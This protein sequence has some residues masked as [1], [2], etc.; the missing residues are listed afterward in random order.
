MLGLP[1]NRRFLAACL[2][3]PTFRAGQALI[4][5]LAGEGDAI[6]E[7]LQKEELL[8]LIP[9]GLAALFSQENWQDGAAMALP[10]PF[11]KPLRLRHRGQTLDLRV[12]ELGQGR[13]E[14]EAK[15]QTLQAA[16]ALGV[17]GGLRV[18][19]D[20]T[21][22]RV[23]AVRLKQEGEGGA[24]WHVQ[25]GA[26]DL[27]LEDA[28]FEA[29]AGP[30]GAV[31]ANELRAPFSGKV[32]AVHAAPGRAVQRGDTLLVIE[33][34]KLEHALAASRDG[35]VKAVMVETGRQATASQVLVTFEVGV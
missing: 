35:I 29:A 17:D 26:V 3:H 7:L 2:R 28:S 24:R 19:V 12:R 5:F 10:C 4:P 31:A 20:E 14:V 16:M 13:L 15:G 25:T 8:A 21:Q 32:I 22:H 33:S 34:M 9:C 1:T 30:G 11:P 6:R 27:V 23:S 18:G